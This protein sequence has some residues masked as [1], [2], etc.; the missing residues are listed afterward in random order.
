[1]VNV[2][3]VSKMVDELALM[4]FFPSD[5]SAR[6]ALVR[7]VCEMVRTDEEAR[8]LVSRALQLYSEWPGVHEL[9]ACF[10]NRFNPR[11]GINA[12]STVYPDGLPPSPDAKLIEAPQ[13]IAL[14][15][16]H[17]ATVDKQLDEDVKKLAELKALPPAKPVTSDFAKRLQ[18]VL[19]APQNRPEVPYSEPLTE[20]RRAE[21]QAMIDA[22]LAKK[23][24]DG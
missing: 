23:R 7:M 24:R 9:R 22:E 20:S 11:D 1:M 12:Y 16:G 10:C 18:E 17:V 14:P 15:P 6:V 13:R 3:K 8:W 19:T 5:E 21:I 4:R 2:A